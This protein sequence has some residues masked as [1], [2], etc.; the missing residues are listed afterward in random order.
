MVVAYRKAMDGRLHR[1]DDAPFAVYG[2][3]GILQLVEMWEIDTGR[4]PRWPKSEAEWADAQWSD[5][6]LRQLMQ[7]CPADGTEREI[8][9]DI[10]AVRG[11]EKVLYREY[12]TQQRAIW[13][14]WV[15]EHLRP[16]C[17]QIHHEGQAHP[18]SG[19]MLETTKLRFYWA[20]MRQSIA[21]HCRHCRGCAL[22]AAY[23]PKKTEG[24]CTGVPTSRSAACEDSY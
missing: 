18:G 6:E 19:R 4:G 16:L 22:R 21:H 24:T 23:I 20:G 15:P 2:D 14:R 13:Q 5:R 9:Q 3:A 10:V 17:L 12:V 11:E 1:D 7:Q 8:S